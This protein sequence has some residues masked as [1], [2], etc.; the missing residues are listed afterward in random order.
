MK[1]VTSDTL[2]KR[3][4]FQRSVRGR[5]GDRR[6]RSAFSSWL[7]TNFWYQTDGFVFGVYG[8]VCKLLIAMVWAANWVLKQFPAFEL[9]FR[10]NWTT[11]HW[12]VKVYRSVGILNQKCKKIGKAFLF[13]FFFL[14]V[15]MLE[16]RGHET[17]NVTFVS[18]SVPSVR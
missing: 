10:K 8:L 3:W 11:K 1:K 18:P 17:T 4:G 13:C 5:C 6:R 9:S 7:S 2:R 12:N 16:V 14:P 15:G